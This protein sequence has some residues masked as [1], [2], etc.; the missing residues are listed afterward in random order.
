M[1]Q[2][3]TVFFV[4]LSSMPVSRV[5][6]TRPVSTVMKVFTW[7]QAT[8]VLPAAVQ[9]L[10]AFRV[11]THRPV[12]CVRMSIICW[13]ECAPIV[14]KFRLALT[15]KTQLSVFPASAGTTLTEIHVHFALLPSWDV[16]SVLQLQHAIAVKLGISLIQLQSSASSAS[17]VF[18]AV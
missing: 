18:R 9:L 11:Q 10:D 5:L 14:A 13:E 2:A 1:L 16:C 4:S 15:A 7:L 3:L 17:T 6:L 8:N 12:W